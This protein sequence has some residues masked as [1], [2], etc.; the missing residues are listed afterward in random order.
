MSLKAT[1]IIRGTHLVR[2]LFRHVARK[3]WQLQEVF[4]AS[5]RQPEESFDVQTMHKM[6]RRC[7]QPISIEGRQLEF[8]LPSTFVPFRIHR[9]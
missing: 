2:I 4:P 9:S 1:R 8:Q 7:L 5:F 3:P 6:M